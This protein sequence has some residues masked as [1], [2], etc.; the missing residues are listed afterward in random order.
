MVMA[1]LAVI[2]GVPLLGV[3]LRTFISNRSIGVSLW[4]GLPLTTS[5]SIW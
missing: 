5:H 3:A 4:D 1:W 2:I